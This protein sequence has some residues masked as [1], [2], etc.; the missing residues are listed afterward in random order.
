MSSR[1]AL[2]LRDYQVELATPAL[3]GHNTIIVA[4][5]GS[6]KTYVA[7]AVAQSVLEKSGGKAKIIFVVNQVMLKYVYVN[8]VEFTI[9]IWIH[10]FIQRSFTNLCFF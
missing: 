1:A 5:T 3:K 6:G 10:I 9:Q 8:T 2:T 4:P 7:V